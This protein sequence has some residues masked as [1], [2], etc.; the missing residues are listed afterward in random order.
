MAD[1]AGGGLLKTIKVAGLYG[2]QAQISE[3]N[4]LRVGSNWPLFKRITTGTDWCLE[5]RLIRF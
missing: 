2:Y 3:S 5:I 4:Y 1:D